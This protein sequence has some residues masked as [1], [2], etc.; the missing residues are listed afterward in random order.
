M[1]AVG[2]TQ[3]QDHRGMILCENKLRLQRPQ[4]K[5]RAWTENRGIKNTLCF[6]VFL[7]LFYLMYN[8]FEERICLA[9]LGS[10]HV[11]TDI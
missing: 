9:T 2:D 11:A 10:T 3:E 6:L 5:E 8:F 1:I 7:F 4:E